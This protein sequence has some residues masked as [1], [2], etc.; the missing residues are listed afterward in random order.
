[1]ENKKGQYT[2]FLVLLGIGAALAVVGA[3]LLIKAIL[4]ETAKN[5]HSVGKIMCI[6]FGSISSVMGF[7]L[8]L[9]SILIGPRKNS[10]KGKETKQLESFKF[11]KTNKEDF[12]A[13]SYCKTK[14][15]SNSKV[16]KNCGASLKN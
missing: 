8:A 9:I 13:C 7:V 6:C 12:V 1:M 10:E 14:N 2:T 3:A 11:T 4:T 16:C 5:G 15:S